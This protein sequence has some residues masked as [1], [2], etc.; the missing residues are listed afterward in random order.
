MS[1]LFLSEYKHRPLLC[2]SGPCLC[3]AGKRQQATGKRQQAIEV[4]TRANAK[5]NQTPIKN[6]N[7][8]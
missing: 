2:R 6:P 5:E 8:N 1:F 7:P 3:A 4:K